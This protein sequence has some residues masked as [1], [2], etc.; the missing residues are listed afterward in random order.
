MVWLLA[1]EVVWLL[2]VEADGSFP[3][4]VR[5]HLLFYILVSRNKEMLVSSV[6]SRREKLESFQSLLK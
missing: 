4:A 2:G 1:A 6:D 5:F 3:A